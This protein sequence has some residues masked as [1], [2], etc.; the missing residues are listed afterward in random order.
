LKIAVTGGTGFIGSHLLPALAGA[1]HGVAALVEAGAQPLPAGVRSVRGDVTTGEGL[2]ETFEGAE[3]V[4]HLAA[5]N[6]VMRETARDPLE[7]YRRVNVEGT[8]RVV[9]AAALSGA[10][11]FVHFSSVK[12]MG[13]GGPEPL[14]EHSPCEPATPYGISKLESEMVVAEEAVSAGMRA[15]LI[16]LPMAYGPGNL[17][18]LPRMIR[19]A[20]RGYPFPDFRSGALRSTI[21]AGNATAGVLSALGRAPAGVSTYILADREDHT[22]AAMFGM[23]S[24][25]LGRT[26]RFMPVPGFLVRLA[27]LVS[28]DFRKVTGPFRVSIRKAEAELGYDPPWSFE[29][30]IAETVAWYRRTSG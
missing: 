12:A 22:P 18:N 24:R 15:V 3:C 17:G 29:A 2:A 26:P 6:H 4:I 25:D 7:A 13:E 27:G 9:R 16:R 11:L 23:I 5:R 21:Y 19:W 1:G 8:R 28:D 20:E 14:D 10:G 30:G